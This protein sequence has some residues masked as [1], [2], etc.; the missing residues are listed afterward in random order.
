[1]SKQLLNPENYRKGFPSLPFQKKRQQKHRLEGLHQQSFNLLQESIVLLDSHANIEFAN[2]AFLNL[3]GKNDLHGFLG[4]AFTSFVSADYADL[5]S[6]FLEFMKTGENAVGPIE[7]ELLL[8]PTT[9]LIAQVTLSPAGFQGRPFTFVTIRDVTEW[10]ATQ[11]ELVSA[12][13]EL[14]QSYSATLEG[15]GRALELRD[16]ES[17]GHTRRVAQV[18]VDLAIDIGLSID[19]IQHIRRGALLHDI[20]KIAIPDSILLKP[21]PLTPDEWLIMKLHPVYAYELLKP[22][23][24]LQHALAIPYNHHEKW[25]GSGYPLALKGEDIPLPARL[26]ALVDVWDALLSDRPYRKGWPEERV[27]AYLKENSGSY[28]D[29]HLTEIFLNRTRSGPRA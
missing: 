22:I 20:G 17:E 4:Q 15:W 3:M 28:F 29:P 7:V 14:E 5:F 6:D 16:I 23:P 18:A 12:H 19:Q 27:L 1:M 25:D 13:M 11:S 26:F 9:R 24:Y 10:N 21:G 2:L 8:N